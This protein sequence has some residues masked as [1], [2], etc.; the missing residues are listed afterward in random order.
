VH[1]RVHPRRDSPVREIDKCKV[2]GYTAKVRIRNFV[3]KGLKRLHDNDDPKGLPPFSADKLRKMIVYLEAMREPRELQLIPVWKA[4]V[5]KG[6]RKGTWSLHVTRNW[7]MT[8]RIES[9]KREICD[10]NFEDYH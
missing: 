7:R 1:S 10:V 5:L 3:H 9:T 8:F 4:H 6:E 2:T